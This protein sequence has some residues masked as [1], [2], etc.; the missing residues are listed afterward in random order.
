MMTMKRRRCVLLVLLLPVFLFGSSS[1]RHVASADPSGFSGVV[2]DMATESPLPGVKV[3]VGDEVTVTDAQGRYRLPVVPGVHEVHL[4]A[5]DYIG[6]TRE[7]CMLE[8]G[9]WV[10]LDFEMVP[11]DPDKEAAAIIDE[12]MMQVSQEPPPDLIQA[13]REKGI[14][15][16]SVEQVPGTIR[17]L[18][19][20]DA[21]V[22]MRMDEYLKGVVPREMPP[23]WPAEA[24]RAQVVAARTYASTRHA[25]GDKGADVCTTTH[26]Q[27]WGPTR[28]ETTD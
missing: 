16:S 19:P 2:V 3:S 26:C 28:Y 27:V 18:M 20:E 15:L 23:Y 6:M 13:I 7:R 10:D 1:L 12:K 4:R 25:H 5:P 21:V 8:K 24:L 17:V 11:R 14:A 9:E 22:E